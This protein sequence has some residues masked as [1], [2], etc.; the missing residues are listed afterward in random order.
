MD[1]ED[2]IMGSLKHEARRKIENYQT[3][4]QEVIE[5]AQKSANKKSSRNL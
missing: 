5:L 1:L 2:L 3:R 4:G